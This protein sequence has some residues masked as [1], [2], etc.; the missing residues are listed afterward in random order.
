MTVPDV[1]PAENQG[2]FI[3][4]FKTSRMQN[5]QDR[6]M[7]FWPFVKVTGLNPKSALKSVLCVAARSVCYR[8]FP[9]RT[10]PCSSKYI[11]LWLF[12]SQQRTLILKTVLGSFSIAVNRTQF[13]IINSLDPLNALFTVDLPILKNSVEGWSWDSWISIVTTLRPAQLR[14]C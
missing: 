2:C 11:I 5:L 1:L 3:C 10:K 12:N 4:N 9:L 6:V 7:A 8:L 13:E 14:N